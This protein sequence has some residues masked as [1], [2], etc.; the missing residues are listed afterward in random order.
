MAL[1]ANEAAEIAK[2]HGLTLQD[3]A[4][5]LTLADTADEA[6][7]IAARFAQ[8]ETKTAGL[9]LVRHL[10]GEPMPTPEPPE[11]AGTPNP[12]L[13]MRRFTSRLFND[14]DPA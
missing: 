14:K 10:F 13:Q 11:P 12:D 2:R 5:L 9:A 6:D 3:A 7:T 4:G 1:T 8:P